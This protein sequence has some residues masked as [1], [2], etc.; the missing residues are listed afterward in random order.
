V[1]LGIVA[2][3][4]LAG[5]LVV[6]GLVTSAQA[7]RAPES[8][9]TA[10]LDGRSVGVRFNQALEPTSAANPTNY[11]LSGGAV[12]HTATLR[13]DGLSVE[14]GISGLT[15]S[16]YTLRV[17][18]VEDLAHH[19]L[20]GSAA[21][22]VQGLL[23][24]DV[25][26]PAQSGSAW[27][28]APGTIEV[29]A[30]GVD[31][32]DNADCFHFLHQERQGDFDLCVR[33]AS[34][35]PEGANTYAKAVLMMRESLARG[36][37]H[38]SVGVYP[39]MGTWTARC[40][41][42]TLKP[43]AVLSGDW[44]VHWPAGGAFPNVWLR[45]RRAG[46]TL[47][48]YGSV[49]GQEWT[50]IGEA[51]TPE[52]PFPETVQVGLGT[53]SHGEQKPAYPMVEVRYEQFG[54]FVVSNASVSFL[55][56]P[57]NTTVEA[58]RLVTFA[59]AAQVTGTPALNLSYQWLK[60]GVAVPGA[61]GPV[62]VTPPVTL[63]DNGA[64]YRLRLSLPGGYTVLSQEATLTV[65]KDVVPPT[66]T[67]VATLV[68]GAL[69]ARFDELLQPQSA[70]EVAHYRLRG[71][72]VITQAELLADGRTV[73]L[74]AA[75]LPAGPLQLTVNG[76]TDLAGNPTQMTVP[77][78]RL[79][80]TAQDIGRVTTPSWAC[81]CS[82]GEINVHAGG[83]NIWTNADSFHFVYG[84]RQGDF[85]VA[86]QLAC[87][88]KVNE[89]TR[90]GLM[91][92][93]TLTAGSRNFFACTYPAAGVKR[94]VSTVRVATS[95]PS[96]LAPGNS[97]VLRAPDFAY[98]HVWFRLKRV[99]NTFTAYY[100][101]NG[102][103]WVQLGEQLTP[104]PPFPATA[105]VGLATTPNDATPGRAVTAQYLNFGDWTEPLGAELHRQSPGAA[106]PHPTRIADGGWRMDHLASAQ[107][108]SADLLDFKP[109]HDSESQLSIALTS[110]PKF[111]ARG[112]AASRAA[113]SQRIP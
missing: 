1:Q 76:V 44:R 7:S 37:R 24:E 6:S 15:G 105:F 26:Q 28:C 51:Y 35:G 71:G 47:T 56:Q 17:T 104:V 66:V 45:L 112:Q 87:L 101:T 111:D 88:S 82:A 34:F 84:A 42:A 31:I 81:A 61:R 20:T 96:T 65:Q 60:N 63:A 46:D 92:R 110:K 70:C 11:H 5:T 25:G 48:A 108:S 80:W 83:G 8:M 39:R 54:D 113:F 109:L 100:G 2:R 85:D 58:N 67:G 49:N 95:G 93:E 36:S 53:T 12:V 75:S 73:R 29:R 64:R 10:S 57:T 33:V 97:Y 19:P 77:V 90:G 106:E 74:Q 102:V 41:P 107:G 103:E 30:G 50:Q 4:L 59:A 99:A 43:S 69:G 72:G 23:S 62:Y 94:W 22:E 91:V 32:W 68:G 3:L 79:N 9:A 98:P 14:L 38:V 40:R 16:N 55:R 52:V 78:R 13:P 86:V 18:G 89:C 27:S 21:G